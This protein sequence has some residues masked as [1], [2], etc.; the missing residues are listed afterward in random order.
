MLCAFKPY[1]LEITNNGRLK[2]EHLESSSPTTKNIISPLS[3]ATKFQSGDLSWSQTLS[4]ICD[5]LNPLYLYYQSA[6]GHQTRQ[7][8]GW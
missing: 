2:P 5:K 4:K 3:M 6:Y 8:G 1:P 7:G